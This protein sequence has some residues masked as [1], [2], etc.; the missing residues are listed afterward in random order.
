MLAFFRGILLF[1]LSGLIARPCEIMCI[2]PCLELPPIVRLE[3]Q[4]I[5]GIPQLIES[6]V[7]ARSGHSILSLQHLHRK[8]LNPTER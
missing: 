2:F 7:K 4:F 6:A 1:E 5:E 3:A 8:E